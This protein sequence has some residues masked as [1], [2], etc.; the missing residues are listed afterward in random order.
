LA[1]LLS[2]SRASERGAAVVEFA[3]VAPLLLLLVFGMISYGY[4][5]S[6]RQALSQGAAE[7]ARAAA[8]TVGSTGGTEQVDAARV[9]LD[10]ALGSY[11]ISC[12]GTTLMKGSTAVGTCSVQIAACVGDTDK[13]CA[14]VSVDYAYE[15]HPL[16]PSVPGLG[17]VLPGHLSYDS[18]A[19]V[20]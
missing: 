14:T 5:L 19:R 3:L 17:I 7:G 11:G 10:E 13:D 12:S 15:E 4:M 20:S 1:G 18:V 16:I 6:F 8:V 2:R 9:A